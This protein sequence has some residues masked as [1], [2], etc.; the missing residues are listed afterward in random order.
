MSNG[1]SLGYTLADS[2]GFVQFALG[3]GSA[4]AFRTRLVS[5]GIP[6]AVTALA[7]IAAWSLGSVLCGRTATKLAATRWLT[8][9]AQAVWLGI[10]YYLIAAASIALLFA[11]GIATAATVKPA[12]F[13]VGIFTLIPAA[14]L[15]AIG[16]LIWR[17]RGWRYNEYRPV[18][19]D[20]ASP[21]TPAVAAT[22]A[23]PPG[24]CGTLRRGVHGLCV[25]TTRCWY[26]TALS[27]SKRLNP[28][29]ACLFTALLLFTGYELAVGT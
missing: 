10:A 7:L 27:L 2:T 13:G 18:D 29:T 16:L 5:L 12:T 19:V 9:P 22:A 8:H 6:F 26:R 21:A 11:W 17:G 25:R 24:C 15:A 1:T 4:T 14:F 3:V 28:I 20:A 23:P